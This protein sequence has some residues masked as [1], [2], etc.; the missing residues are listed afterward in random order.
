MSKYFFFFQKG[1]PVV[2]GSS[3]KNIGIETLLDAIIQYLPSPLEFSEYIIH[4]CFKNDIIGKSFKVMHDKQRGPLV[5]FRM[6]S[7]SLEKVRFPDLYIHSHSLLLC[8]IIYLEH[9]NNIFFVEDIY[10]HTLI[11]IMI[12]F[13]LKKMAY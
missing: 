1:V 5:F 8:L 13:L 10:I 11:L 3:Y 2:C 7:G 12:S 9:K 4:E 6:F